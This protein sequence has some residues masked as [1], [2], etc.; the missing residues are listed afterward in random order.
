[1][2]RSYKN[3]LFLLLLC[4]LPILVTAQTVRIETNLGII[5]IELDATSAPQTVENFLN[6]VNRGD[7]NAS[8][9]HRS[10]NNAETEAN[11]II[12]GGGF[13]QRD[14][15]LIPIPTEDP[16]ANEFEL[17][18]ERGTIAM[19]SGRARSVLRLP[20]MMPAGK[21]RRERTGSIGM[22]RNLV[23]SRSL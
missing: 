1:M 22:R 19:A 23:N 5:D 20:W 12:Q 8:I 4:T 10:A 3:H 21:R 6:Y 16:V 18:N 7:Y 14:D 9:I 13:H 2:K 15:E 17:L 11:F